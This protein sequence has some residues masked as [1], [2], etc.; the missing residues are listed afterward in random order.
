MNPQK[1]IA[2]QTRRTNLEDR[3]TSKTVGACFVVGATAAVDRNE[4]SQLQGFYINISRNSEHE[5]SGR[6]LMKQNP[7]IGL[8]GV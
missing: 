1:Y 2:T 7:E 3:S 8:C 4:E 5:F 6:S